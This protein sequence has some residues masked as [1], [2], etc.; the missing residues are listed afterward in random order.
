MKRAGL[1][2]T[3]WA[4]ILLAAIPASASGAGRSQEPGD[5][6]EVHLRVVDETGTP[7]PRARVI[8]WPVS[9]QGDRVRNASS[10]STGNVT[11]RAVPHD[12]Y[13]IYVDVR[14]RPIATQIHR[15]VDGSQTDLG[16]LTVPPGVRVRGKVVNPAGE[17]LAGVRVETP[18]YSDDTGESPDAWE[19]I[20]VLTG[21]DGGFVLE[22]VPPGATWMG[23]RSDGQAGASHDLRLRLGLSD[24][25]RNFEMRPTVLRARGRLHVEFVDGG[26]FPVGPVRRSAE[27]RADWLLRTVEQMAFFVMTSDRRWPSRSSHTVHRNA[28]PGPPIEVGVPPGTARIYLGL[29][30]YRLVRPRGLHAMPPENQWRMDDL[31]WWNEVEV[32][33]GQEIVVRYEVEPLS[34][35]ELNEQVSTV[36]VLVRR[37]DS[38]GTLVAV[39]DAQVSFNGGPDGTTDVRGRVT[40]ERVPRGPRKV[41]VWA[42]P[43]FRGE[44]SLDIENATEHLEIDLSIGA[45]VTPVRLQGTVESKDGES[46]GGA[47]LRLAASVGSPHYGS[48]ETFIEDAGTFSLQADL[49]EGPYVATV[50]RDGRRVGRG[51]IWV[52]AESDQ[53]VEIV[54]RSE[55]P[56]TTATGRVQGLL[57][58]MTSKAAFAI[59]GRMRSPDSRY[60]STAVRK[61]GSFEFDALPAGE[62]VFETEGWDCIAVVVQKINVLPGVDTQMTMEV[63]RTRAARGRVRGGEAG[64]AV[65][66]SDSEGNCVGR[67]TIAADGTFGPLPVPSGEIVLSVVVADGSMERSVHSVLVGEA[68]DPIEMTVEPAAVKVRI[69]DGETGA[70]L[71]DALVWLVQEQPPAPFTGWQ[72]P[73][74]RPDRHGEIELDAMSPGQWVVRTARSEVAFEIGPGEQ[75]EIIVAEPPGWIPGVEYRHGD[76]PHIR[77]AFVSGTGRRFDGAVGQ[78]GPYALRLPAGDYEVVAD[79]NYGY[80]QTLRLTVPGGPVQLPR[81]SPR[82]ALRILVPETY[83]DKT[84]L[85]AEL[86]LSATGEIFTAARSDVIVDRPHDVRARGLIEFEH[87]PAGEYQVVVRATDGR[88]FRGTATVVAFTENDVVA[89]SQR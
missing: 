65:V 59:R 54:V 74:Y 1:L 4:T 58:G 73:V 83:L 13:D 66:A 36:T 19:Q 2:A 69:V 8:L 44:K 62:W 79:S 25:S 67:A 46:L 32:Q 22:G 55:L 45:D 47:E 27:S 63:P 28:S 30:G 78:T 51:R 41:W 48:A 60:E 61:D 29:K 10:D 6:A 75:R 71:P 72:T 53:S 86:T 70:P 15:H 20:T 52:G 39:P 12:V 38:T 50:S 5:V 64:H 9:G 84:D 16:E 17:P 37:Q 3:A 56:A 68:V 35:A 33:P 21:S 42:E 82:G 87:V 49:A 23:L 76:V 11:L 89:R 14:G 7:L 57:V 43:W 88:E 18:R 26:G 81:H 77:L 80:E 24:E 40:I 85:R 31:A 34:Q